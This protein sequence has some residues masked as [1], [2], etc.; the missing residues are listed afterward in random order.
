M[1]AVN[2][3]VLVTPSY[4]SYSGTGGEMLNEG[5]MSFTNITSLSVD[6][7]FT[8][9]FE[10]YV[11]IMSF[12][13][14]TSSNQ[15]M[16]MRLRSGGVTNSESTYSGQW[17]YSY[18]NTNPTYALVTNTSQAYLGQVGSSGIAGFTN[19]MKISIM[20]PNMPSKTIVKTELASDYIST[21]YSGVYNSIFTYNQAKVFDGVEIRHNN[22]QNFTGTM[23]I[24]GVRK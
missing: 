14:A 5:Q 1:G 7:I 16:M 4:F 24:Y 8:S 10:D 22:N 12:T 3:L 6:N 20:N 2:G 15:W 18:Y 9:D 23:N 21:Y 17:T 11:M 19:F 13:S